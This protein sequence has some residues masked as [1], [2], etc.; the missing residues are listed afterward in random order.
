MNAAKR[1]A[2]AALL[3]AVVTVGTGTTTTWITGP[4]HTAYATDAPGG[5]T[6]NTGKK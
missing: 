1:L 4:A 5:P 2:L 3:A 6:D